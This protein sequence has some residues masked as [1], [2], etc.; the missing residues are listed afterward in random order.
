MKWAITDPLISLDTETTGKDPQEARVV[1]IAL[2]VIVPGRDVDLRTALINPGVPIPAEASAVHGISDE[3]VAAEGRP[4]AE[5]LDAFVAD[6]ALAIR[7]GAA[8]VAQ[9]AS[10]D[11]TVLARECER[12]G[13]PSIE[14]RL[15]EPLTC[16]VD[17]MVLDKQCIKYRRRVSP[18]QGA[19]VLKTLAA[20]YGVAWDDDKAHGAAYDALIGARVT[21][22]IAQWAGRSRAEL[23][24]RRV[25][26]FDPPKPMHRDDAGKFLALGAMSL[27]ELHVAQVGWYREQAE[28]LA[29]HWRREAIQKETD[30]GSDAPPGDENMH[31]DERRVVLLQ[32][33]EELRQRADGINTSWPIQT[34]NG[35]QA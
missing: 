21:W 22:R 7:G 17:P 4:P 13:L 2:A 25:G 26:P 20:V 10:Y 3:R 5:V 35:G 19:R 27:P 23:M 24:A 9:N 33:A 28:G 14:D 30:S 12:H 6:I 15:G 34:P 11:L 29:Q 31:A 32:E 16:V 18:D 1:D 8:L